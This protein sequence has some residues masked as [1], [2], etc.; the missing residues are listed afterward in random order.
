LSDKMT[1]PGCQSHSSSVATAYKNGQP[2]PSCDLS[3]L[4]SYEIENTR[5]AY[6]PGELTERHVRLLI[7]HDVTQRR[8][9]A[10]ESWIYEFED[11]AA[12]LKEARS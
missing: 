12:K 10:L 6:G 3:A 9:A 11:L 2:C 4:I 5:M 1:C 8:W 7:R